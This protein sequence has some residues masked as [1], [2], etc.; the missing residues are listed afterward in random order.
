MKRKNLFIVIFVSLITLSFIAGGV[1]LRSEE[2]LTTI[3]Q[4]KG[5]EAGEHLHDEH[6]HDETEEH[7]EHLHDDHEEP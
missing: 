5:E 6:L 2:H 7:D 1:Y 4:K 3:V